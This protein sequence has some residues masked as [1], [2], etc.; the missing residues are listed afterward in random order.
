MPTRPAPLPPPARG[1]SSEYQAEPLPPPRFGIDGAIDSMH[2]LSIKA[3]KAIF[4][5]PKT[6]TIPQPATSSILR[7][8]P[9]ALKPSIMKRSPSAATATSQYSRRSRSSNHYTLKLFGVDGWND[10][11]DD[12]DA[13]Y[14]GWDPALFLWLKELRGELVDLESEIFD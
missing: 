6:S 8:L 4:E 1:V 5:K 10:D 9:A 12:D 7:R 14:A 11:D 13:G 3:R 2:N